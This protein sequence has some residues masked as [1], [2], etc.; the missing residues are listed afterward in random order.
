MKN[1]GPLSEQEKLQI[2]EKVE[3]YWRRWES[4][5]SLI[6]WS[7]KNGQCSYLEHRT[8]LP[9]RGRPTKISSGTTWKQR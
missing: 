7:F 5:G 3:I 8:I 2:I 6:G 9:K 4:I 1:K